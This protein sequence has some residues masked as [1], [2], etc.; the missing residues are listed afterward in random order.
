LF[1]LFTGARPTELIQAELSDVQT[2]DGVLCLSIT[3]D[4]GDSK[5]VKTNAARRV[6]PIHPALLS[7]GFEEYLEALRVQRAPRVFSGIPVGKRKGGDAVC[8]WYNERYRANHLPGFKEQ[9]KVLY[10]FR[11]THITKA[12]NAEIEL[13]ALQQWVGHEPKQM[14]AT[15]HYDKGMR[16][17]EQLEAISR[18]HW[19]VRALREMPKG[20]REMPVTEHRTRKKVK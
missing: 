11:H 5:Q 3:D 10:S 20:W 2:Q 14:G 7:V 18:V 17:P 8:K 16:A 13:R 12:L 15:R 4:G 19:D 1:A 6:V 9:N